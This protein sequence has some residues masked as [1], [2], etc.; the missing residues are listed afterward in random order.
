MSCGQ[1]EPGQECTPNEPAYIPVEP[2]G[3]GPSDADEVALL[4][5]EFGEPNA[6]GVYSAVVEE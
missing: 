6:D 2:G 1:C 5:E 4:T 3:N